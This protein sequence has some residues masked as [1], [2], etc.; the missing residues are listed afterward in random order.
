MG[1]GSGWRPNGRVS[2][3][4]QV[5]RCASASPS[6]YDLTPLESHALSSHHL[7][8]TLTDHLH[9]L[10]SPASFLLQH[11]HTHKYS[12]ST[13]ALALLYVCVENQPETELCKVKLK[14]ADIEKLTLAIEELYYFEFI[15]DDL[16]VRGF[17]GQYEEQMLPG[18][19]V[20]LRAV[21]APP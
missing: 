19:W 17:I 13:L 1:P 7:P 14:K 12:H 4:Y 5:Q 6:P 3:P 2:V 20:N 15:L 8:L 21:F 16:P 18:T 11:T 10:R 9:P